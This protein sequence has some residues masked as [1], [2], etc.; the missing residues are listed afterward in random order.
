MDVAVIGLGVFGYSVAVELQSKGINVLAMDSQMDEVERVKNHVTAA[1]RADATDINAL[2]SAGVQNMD[3]AVIAIGKHTGETVV[4]TMNLKKLGIPR[5]FAR[6]IDRQFEQSLKDVGA[7]YVFTLEWQMGKQI[8]AVVSAPNILEFISFPGEYSLL[9]LYAPADWQGKTIIDL[10]TR[11]RFGVNIV[12][13]KKRIPYVDES[14]RSVFLIQTNALP[15]PKDVI[16]RDEI[17]VL[18]GPTEKITALMD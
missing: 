11:K 2:K 13:I 15:Q 17:M 4:V 16:R 8:A 14:G 10:D 18:I 5:I 12:A 3:S 1:V 9:E 6:S 7:H